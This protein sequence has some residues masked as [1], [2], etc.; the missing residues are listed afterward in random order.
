MGAW[1]IEQ[2]CIVHGIYAC[3]VGRHDGDLV[4]R[5]LEALPDNELTG[6]RD[7]EGLCRIL[8]Y[9]TLKNSHFAVPSIHGR[10][11]RQPN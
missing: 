6:E 10:T 8:F 9:G 11:F 7:P 5:L 4:S 2:V 3:I 1:D